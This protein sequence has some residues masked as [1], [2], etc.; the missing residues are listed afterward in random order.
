MGN[1]WSRKD[2]W[3]FEEHDLVDDLTSIR[4]TTTGTQ[5][6][7]SQTWGPKLPAVVIHEEAREYKVGGPVNCREKDCHE[8]DRDKTPGTAEVKVEAERRSAS[9]GTSTSGRA[10]SFAMAASILLRGQYVVAFTGAGISVDSGEITG[11]LA[12]NAASAWLSLRADL[13]VL[14]VAATKLAVG[15]CHYLCL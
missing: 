10:D 15:G 6:W 7:G 8:Q 9:E 14:L 13:H 2:A 4:S 12:S 1:R 3:T 5:L 11:S